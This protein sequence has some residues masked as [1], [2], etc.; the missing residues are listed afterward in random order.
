[1]AK[2]YIFSLSSSFLFIIIIIIINQCLLLSTA[3]ECQS[4]SMNQDQ[5][6]NDD[7]DDDRSSLLNRM[8]H[9]KS[10]CP[11]I[12]FNGH[13]HCTVLSS[14]LSTK[15]DDQSIDIRIEC[16]HTNA[17]ILMTDIENLAS[18]NST[19]NLLELSVKDSNLTH[20]YNLPSGLYNVQKMFLDNTGIDLETIRESQE[21]LKSLR[22][23]RISNENF[24][25]IQRN[26]FNGMEELKELSL[27]KLG[28]AYI[29]IE[30]FVSLQDSLTLLEL[31]SNK[32][33][34]VPTAVQSLSH[35]ECLDLSGNDIKSVTDGNTG[36]FSSGLRRL[37]R[38]G[39]NTMNCSCEFGKSKFATWLRTH[40]IKGV[41]CAMPE[42]FLDKDVSN[43]AIEEFCEPWPNSNVRIESNCPMIIIIIIIFITLQQLLLLLLLFG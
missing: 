13:C 12:H 14:M 3:F 39:I 38:L 17:S 18:C 43:T 41:Q 30:A 2:L 34:T 10:F 42:R 1:M 21:L 32:I 19:I 27:N 25:E 40:G 4:I 28:M 22:V 26:L 29:N 33:R 6:D 7:D 11:N 31:R 20:L 36:I 9:C 35:L 16:R 8:P 15:Q 37:K 24:T 23:L 5:N